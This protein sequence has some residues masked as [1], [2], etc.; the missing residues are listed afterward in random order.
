MTFGDRLKELRISAGLTQDELAAKLNT[1][2]Q[3][4]SRYENSSREPNIKTAKRIA[5]VLGVSL[6]S[7]AVHTP[8]APNYALDIPPSLAIKLS[9]LDGLDL[10]K[11]EA[12]ADGLLAQ[13]KYRSV[14][15]TG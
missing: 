5:D 10:S 11:V 2:K 1:S 3:S 9:H 6:E 8:P 12:Y 7:L 15:S 13:D 4:I 14:S